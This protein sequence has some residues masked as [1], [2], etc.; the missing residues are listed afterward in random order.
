MVEDI[1]LFQK[2]LLSLA[3]GT[4][5]GIERERS[6]KGELFAG[7]RTFML[8]CLFGLLI[9]FL[10]DL[11]ASQLLIYIGLFSIA[12][13]TIASYILRFYRTKQVGLTTEIAFLITFIIGL[14]LFF[15]VYPYFLSISLGIILTLILL[16]KGS[17][18]SFAKH[19]TA[20]EIRD[21]VIFAIAAFIILPLL[22][23]EAI[24][25]FH[26]IHPYS[27]WLAIVFV[28]SVSFAAYVAMK[29][30][31]AKKGAVLT[32]LFG[33]FVSSTSVAI[34]MSEKV[35]QN[36]KFLYSSVFAVG[37][38]S[39]TMFLRQLFMAS[40]FNYNLF[41]FLFLPLILIG[42]VGYL[43]S[44]PAL[45]KSSRDKAIVNIGSPL[46][47][48]PAL[49]FS[50]SLILILFVSTLMQNYF[51]YS[52]IF[53]IALVTGFLDVDAITISLATLV[54]GGL[55]ISTAVGGIIIAGMSNTI[56]KWILTYWL[57]KKKMGVEIGRIYGAFLILG[58]IF[59]ILSSQI[60]SL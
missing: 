32:G 49:Q 41:P 21:A 22:P 40:F 55:P 38:A 24:D 10:S 42:I 12:G 7:V 1:I 16:S 52:G 31:G 39:S 28:L 44:Y 56:F 36:K 47:I 13:I 6:G 51:G 33:G 43:L 50:I 35:K 20:K 4:L 15:E 26:I 30:F 45:K 19:L 27:I 5:I 18:H 9:G 37:I 29:A 8:V 58:I 3:I 2:I 57:G 54:F 17:L 25:P 14:I 59:L 46:A 11:M 60:I 23:T 34:V 53:L 48:K